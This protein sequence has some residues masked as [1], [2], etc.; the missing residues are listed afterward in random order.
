MLLPH[1]FFG[2]RW[3]SKFNLRVLFWR[4][5]LLVGTITN[6]F[7][8]FLAL[9]LI[10]QDVHIGIAVAV[11]FASLPYNCFL[12]AAVLRSPQRTSPHMLTVGIWF[13]LMTVV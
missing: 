8:S 1:G 4:D 9:V 3:H 13:V 2:R 11:H 6:L 10:S 7:A 12:C 5:L